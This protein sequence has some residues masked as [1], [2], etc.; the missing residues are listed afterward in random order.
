MLRSLG[1]VMVLVLLMWFLAQP[2]DSDEQELRT[3]DPSADVA[4]FSADVPAAPAPAGLTEQW[5]STSS[6]LSADT[7]GSAT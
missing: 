4:A 6:T 1:V 7:C 2:P 5:R 3:V